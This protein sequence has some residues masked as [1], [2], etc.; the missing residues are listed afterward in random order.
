[1]DVIEG[2]QIKI[3]NGCAYLII[4][5]SGHL[6]KFTLSL[7]WLN[8][9]NQPV[10]ILIEDVHL[11]VVPSQQATVDWEEEEQRVQ[12]VKAERLAKAE[13]SYMRSQTDG[14]DYICWCCP[15]STWLSD[16]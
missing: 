7:H 9:G 5:Q 2:R 16:L 1:M 13:R 15:V 14:K 6:G 10:E 11:L 12:A 8:L 3:V 4:K